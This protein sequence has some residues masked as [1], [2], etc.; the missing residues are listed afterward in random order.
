MKAKIAYQRAGIYFSLMLKAK[1]QKRRLWVWW[2]DHDS[3]IRANYEFEFEVR[4]GKYEYSNYTLTANDNG[5]GYL[6]RRLYNGIVGLKYYKLV[7]YFESSHGRLD[8][9]LHILDY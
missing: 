6:Q 3:W 5:E 4:C 9:Q 2:R 7:A 1:A 8:R